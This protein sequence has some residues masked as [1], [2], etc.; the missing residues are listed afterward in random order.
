M[1]TLLIALSLFAAS[2]L[3]A[4]DTPQQLVGYYPFEETSGGAVL[5]AS[6]LG[7]NGEIRHDSRG[8]KRVPGRS[9][10][11]IEFV[12]GDPTQRNQAGCV[13][14]SG[15]DQVDFTKGLTVALWVKLTKFV[16]EETYE[17]VSNTVGDRGQ[18]FRLTIFYQC[19]SLRS[20]EGGSG[21]TWGAQTNP[22]EFL[23]KTDQWYHLAG[24]YDGS[25]YRVYVDGVL[26]GQSESNLTLTPGLPVVCLGSYGGGYAYGLDG[27]IDDVRLYNYARPAAEIVLDAKLR[28]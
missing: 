21:K 15:L 28:D 5:D 20:G 26:A 9:G 19:F 24:T 18:G 23:P 3:L 16:R 11:A 6:G 14:L 10:G 1:R 17:L 25:V 7:H 2:V 4:Q 27:I 13:A 12:A 22:A 8:V